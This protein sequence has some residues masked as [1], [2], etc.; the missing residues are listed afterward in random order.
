MYPFEHVHIRDRHPHKGHIDVCAFS[1][2]KPLQL[3]MTVMCD[4]ITKTSR[5]TTEKMRSHC[6]VIY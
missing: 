2:L 6:E 3:L 1:H 5:H 4:L